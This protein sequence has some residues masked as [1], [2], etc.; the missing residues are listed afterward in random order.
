MLEQVGIKAKGQRLAHLL[1]H[2]ELDALICSGPRQGKQFTYALLDDRA[3]RVKALSREAALAQLS[4]RFFTGH[5]P[6]LPQDFAWW[7]GLT[8]SD[9]KKGMESVRDRLSELELD[10]RTY[11]HT[12]SATPPA[13]K[14]PVVHFLPN[15][16]EHL[17][18]YK[19]RSA[20]FDR[21]RIPALGARENVLFNHLV[22]LDGRVIG[23]WRRTQGTSE[24][25][26]TLIARLNAA[27]KKALSTAQ[28]RLTKYLT[29]SEL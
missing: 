7:S 21:E 29:A 13:L 10:G 11:W 5:G 8:L 22:I 12:E 18:A 4:L 17:I 24:I 14:E 27:E 16:D 26:I 2:A 3:P 25:E 20:A 28:A 1:V 19:E 6:A 15:Y 9:A 23:G